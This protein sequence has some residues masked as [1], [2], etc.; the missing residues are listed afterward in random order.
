MSDWVNG[1]CSA[2]CGNGTVQSTRNVT[3][4]N[5][6]GGNP[7]PNDTVTTLDCFL[8][9]CPVGMLLYMKIYSNCK[10]WCTVV[11]M[12]LFSYNCC[13]LCQFVSRF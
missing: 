12:Q 10:K 6:Y 8:T 1:T 7:C 4:I 13:E 9:P 11:L 2:T 3:Q 5:L